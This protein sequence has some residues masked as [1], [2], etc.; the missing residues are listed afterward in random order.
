[1]GTRA[2]A[3]L[4]AGI[5]WCMAAPAHADPKSEVIAKTRAAMSSYDSMDYEAARKLLNQALAIAKRAKLDKDPIVARVY[6]DLGI[7]QLAGSD[8][9]AAKVAFL[10]AAQIDPKITI[11]AAYKSAELVKMLEEAKAAA[12]DPGD[13]PDVSAECASAR[14]L[15]HGAIESGRAGSAQPIDVTIGSE[16]A[17]AKVIVMFR[18]EGA[19]D[20]TEARLSRQAG[21]HF[22]GAIPASAMHGALVHYYIAAYDANNKVLAAKGSSGA[23]NILELG[24]GR[25]AG[26]TE[27]PLNGSTGPVGRGAVTG[28][29]RSAPRGGG[30]APSIMLAV[31]G[32]TGFGYVS[33]KTEGDNVVQTCCIGSSLV[34]LSPEVGYYASPRLVL[35]LAFRLG[36]PIG[37]N[38]EGHST[39]APSVFV[40]VRYALSRSGEGL[41]V[42][43][44]LGGGVLR[45]TLKL[46]D[47]MKGMDTDIVAQGPLLVGAGV[48]YTKQLGGSLAL[49]VD[50]TAIAG[51]AVV[52][53]VGSAIRLNTGISADLALGLAVG[54]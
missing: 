31:A 11:D 13:A 50:V 33:G 45:N 15:Q 10:S 36:L 48:G 5:V 34:V 51:I 23:P 41:R 3:T 54:F 42:M 28:V 9:E 44:E 32:G 4:I 6:L 49:F 14:G 20:F 40:R 18:P 7:A 1:M 38:I 8:L 25:S 12:G 17:P 16:L 30:K 2:V 21:C 29:S 22:V 37:A 39:M 52:D 46:S 19:I 47:D 27:D 53:K 35:G 24:A 26:E 43:A